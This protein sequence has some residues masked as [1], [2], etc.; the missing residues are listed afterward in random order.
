MT[1]VNRSAIVPRPAA[2]LF[3]LVDRVEDYPKRFAWCQGAA[4][5]ERTK[6]HVVAKLD[7]KHGGL[8]TSFTTRNTLHPTER[9]ALH[10]VDGPFT[11][12]EGAW[13]FKPLGE[14]GCKVALDLRFSV[15]NRLVGSALA[16]GFKSLADRLVDDFVRAALATA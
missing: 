10:L 14:D 7:L 9:I 12:L 6:T 15:S 16:L 2:L 11:A 13:H 1:N 5:L 3:E 8:T 4:V